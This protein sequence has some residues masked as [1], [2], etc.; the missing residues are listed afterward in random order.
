MATMS[1]AEVI[2]GDLVPLPKL[3]GEF[4]PRQFAFIGGPEP[5]ISLTTDKGHGYIL[6][7]DTMIDLLFDELTTYIAERAKK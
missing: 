6:L 1:D 4:S 3:T 2:E 5:R 7:S